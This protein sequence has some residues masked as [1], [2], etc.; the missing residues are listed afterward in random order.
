MKKAGADSVAESIK[1]DILEGR[2]RYGAPLEPSRV[3]A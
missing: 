3:L 2:L 1:R